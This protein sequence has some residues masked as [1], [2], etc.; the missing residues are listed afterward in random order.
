MKVVFNRT[1][2]LSAWADSI[3]VSLD[4]KG[5]KMKYFLEK[6]KTSY[7]WFNKICAN[8]DITVSN[9]KLWD[10]YDAAKE[11]G[12]NPTAPTLSRDDD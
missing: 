4:I 7:Y 2:D 12:L 1:M 10:I 5:I 9:S 11:L 3:K 6:A 8:A